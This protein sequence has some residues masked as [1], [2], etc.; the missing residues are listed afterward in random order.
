MRWESSS[1]GFVSP[2]EFVPIAIR[3]GLMG[4][5]DKHS[6]ETACAQLSRWKGLGYAKNCRLSVNVLPDQ[7]LNAGFTDGVKDVLERNNLKPQDVEFEFLESD[8]MGGVESVLPTLKAMS[9]MGMLLAI[10]DFGT[11]HSSLSRLSMLPIDILKIDRAFILGIGTAEA[12]SII[13]VILQLARLLKLKVIAEG[14]ET[15]DQL[16]FLLGLD[17]TIIQGYYFSK[18]L[19]AKEMTQLLGSPNMG[20]PK[21][22]G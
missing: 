4:S 21:L 14:I 6:F 11:G 17:C 10:D 3:E 20:L 16:D 8:L 2:D 12:E 9:D 18:P 19:K 15:K 13:K 5:I 1:L 7:L 22:K